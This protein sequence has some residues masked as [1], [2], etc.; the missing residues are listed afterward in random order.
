MI[1]PHIKILIYW[2]LGFNILSQATE[3]NAGA[4][5]LSDTG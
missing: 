3:W 5:I 4:D 1:Y 2:E